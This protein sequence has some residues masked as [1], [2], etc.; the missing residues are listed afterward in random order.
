MSAVT[1][2]RYEVLRTLR[3]RM[4]F[5]FPLLFPLV[6]YVAF[7]SEYRHAHVGSVSFATYELGGMITFGAL[8]GALSGGARIALD[9]SLGWTRQLR[10]TPLSP[11]AYLATKIATSYL[12]V[13]MVIAVLGIAGAGFGVQLPAA[14]WV[15]LAGLVGLGVFPFVALGIALGNLLG[16]EAMGPALGGVV[17]FFALLGGA[18]G[19]VFTHGLAHRLI[20]ALPTYWLVETAT[21]VVGGASWP[22]KGWIVI[23]AWSAATLVAARAAW[24]RAGRRA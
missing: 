8:S 5:V 1:Y 2:A 19:R 7:V 13:A 24:R 21:V 22:V 4:S 12:V 14:R 20:E 18:F 3:N 6:L 23:A 15:E 17:T 11:R 16:P 10:T 9:R